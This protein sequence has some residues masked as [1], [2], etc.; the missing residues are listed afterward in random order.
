MMIRWSIVLVPTLLLAACALPV[1]LKHKETGAIVQC[2]PYF[3]LAMRRETL[4]CIRDYQREGY[5]C[6]PSP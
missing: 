4:H 6:I 1:H 2:G 3:T 5:E